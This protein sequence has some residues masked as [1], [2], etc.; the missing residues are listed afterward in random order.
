MVLQSSTAANVALIQVEGERGPRAIPLR[1]LAGGEVVYV[2]G[3]LATQRPY[4]FKL[5]RPTL[6]VT[7][8]D[9]K[10]AVPQPLQPSD[11]TIDRSDRFGEEDMQAR[12]TGVAVLMEQC[13]GDAVS[14]SD[15]IV[16]EVAG[17]LS[18]S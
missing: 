9:L 3:E 4:V 7:F 1:D 2:Y 14:A 16:A 17:Q 18:S 11:F 6:P 8:A 13:G 12:L 5:P 10:A 15:R